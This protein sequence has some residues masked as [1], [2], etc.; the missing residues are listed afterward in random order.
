MNTLACF[1]PP[2]MIATVA[3]ELGLAA[4]V[5]LRYRLN[6]TRRIMLAILVCLAGFQ[7]A[8]F[9]VCGQYGSS[10]VWS[11]LGYVLITFLPALG[12]HLALNIGHLRSKFTVVPY[13]LAAG[14]AGLFAFLP[15]ELNSSVCTG[16]YVVFQLSAGL[17]V[18]WMWYYLGGVAVGLALA[19]RGAATGR[20]PTRPAFLWLAL[21]YLSFILP[22]Y[23]IYWLAP[24]TGRGLPS[25]MCGFAVLLALI[26]GLKIAP[27]TNS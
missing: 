3:I 20:V 21:G 19:A 13:A 27:R 7:L 17:S 2:I 12:I 26:I 22:S 25:I 15:S 6:S 24:A 4:W 9:S 16:N 8:E 23:S 1:S 18:Y 11:R 5:L 14:F 10:L